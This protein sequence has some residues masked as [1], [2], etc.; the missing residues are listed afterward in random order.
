MSHG[1]CTNWT[2]FQICLWVTQ[3]LIQSWKCHQ[4]DVLKV[5]LSSVQCP[6]S[7]AHVLTLICVSMAIQGVSVCETNSSSNHQIQSGFNPL[8]LTGPDTLLHH[9]PHPPPQFISSLPPHPF[10]LSLSSSTG[11]S[12]EIIYHDN[13]DIMLE[14]SQVSFV[15]KSVIFP[16]TLDQENVFIQLSEA[17]GTTDVH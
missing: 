7:L 12:A 6:S 4:T 13:I 17:S 3:G 5:W 14:I 10:A 8:W 1:P 15:F 9:P 2:L 11:N 16:Q